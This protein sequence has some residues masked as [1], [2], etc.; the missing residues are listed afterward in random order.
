MK[1]LNE[2]RSSKKVSKIMSPLILSA[3]IIGGAVAMPS[4]AMAGNGWFGHGDHHQKQ[5]HRGFKR[6]EKMAD[7]L[8]FSDAQ[9][10][11][12]EEIVTAAKSQIGEMNRK[13]MMKQM[14]TLDPESSDY[15]SQVAAAADQIAEKVKSRIVTMAEV[16]KQVHAILTDEQKLEMQRLMKKRMK[17]MEK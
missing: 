15:E 16:R 6:F 3:A 10:Q 2:M 8:D 12:L 4:V 9:E 11:Q 14:M 1:L 7:H 13:D 17:R 5:E